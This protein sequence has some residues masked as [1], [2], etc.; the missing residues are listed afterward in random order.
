MSRVGEAAFKHSMVSLAM[1]ILVGIVG[2]SLLV[3][4][5]YTILLIPVALLGLV[6]FALAIVYGWATYG[7]AL[8]RIIGRYLKQEISPTWTTFG[9][10]FMFTLL[11]N[12]VTAIPIVGGVIGILVSLAGLGAVFLTR[13]GMRRFIPAT[14]VDYS[15]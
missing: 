6:I 1:G 11:F 12:L 4:L 14:N 5:A 2:T 8:G 15:D 13:F 10:A 3:L 7:V 9:G